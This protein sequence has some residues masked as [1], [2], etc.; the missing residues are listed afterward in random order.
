MLVYHGDELAGPY[1]IYLF[2]FSVRCRF[3]ESTSGYVFTLGGVAVSWRSIKQSCITDSTM[4][5]EYVA[6]SEAA[7]EA[8]WLKKFLM[9]LGVIAKA[10]DP[11][12]LYCDN[13]GAIAQGK[14]PKNHRK[15]KHIERK[16]HLVRE[17][18]YYSIKDCI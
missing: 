14:E 18:R 15:G 4:E 16:Y 17:R 11:M 5:A 8:I 10:V 6:T 13:S 7:K 12:I 3:E 2:R 9:E 1:R